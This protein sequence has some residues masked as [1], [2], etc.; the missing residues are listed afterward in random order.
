MCI[1]QTGG[2]YAAQGRG[3][4]WSVGFILHT[5]TPRSSWP[6]QSLVH[7]LPLNLEFWLQHFRCT[8]IAWVYWTSG[9][10]VVLTLLV[11][12]LPWLSWVR[13]PGASVILW[14][15]HLHEDLW[16]H[17]ILVAVGKSL[18][19]RFP[20]LSFYWAYCTGFLCW[21]STYPALYYIKGPGRTVLV[22]RYDYV[23]L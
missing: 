10:F 13:Q 9:S 22:I 20:I 21:L 15:D 3:P 1:C 8:L 5:R 4:Y 6:C 14:Q 19:T 11:P 23:L 12:V 18:C 2:K 16:L 17:N 7:Y